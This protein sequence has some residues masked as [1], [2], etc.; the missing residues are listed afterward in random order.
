MRT[1][2]SGNSAGLLE[3]L[4]MKDSGIFY[5]A[6]R[7]YNNDSFVTVSSNETVVDEVTKIGLACFKV[8]V[9]ETILS[10]YWVISFRTSL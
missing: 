8:R 3:F 10:A 1:W 7:Y 9:R 6:I 4:C 5:R 2:R